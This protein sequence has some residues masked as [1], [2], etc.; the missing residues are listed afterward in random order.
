MFFGLPDARGKELCGCFPDGAAG[1]PRNRVACEGFFPRGN[2]LGED[3]PLFLAASPERAATSLT[4]FLNCPCVQ[5]T[6]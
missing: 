2:H 4:L 3:T 5:M 6:V 1:G